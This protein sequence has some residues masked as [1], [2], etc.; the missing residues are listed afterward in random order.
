MMQISFGLL[1]LAIPEKFVRLDLIYVTVL[2]L[3]ETD[4][5]CFLKH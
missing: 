4:E 3:K 1:H 2:A 5:C